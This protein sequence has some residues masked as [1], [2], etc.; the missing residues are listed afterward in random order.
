MSTR[1]I[2]RF[3]PIL[4][5]LLLVL[6][7]SIGHAQVTSATLSGTVTDGTG[8]VI[9]GAAVATT[10]ENTGATRSAE[11]DARGV[12]H[13]PLLSVGTYELR[14]ELQ[15]FQAAV[16]PGIRLT[17]GLE[18]TVN[19]S[20]RV[21][22]VTESVE[23]TGEAPVVAT[24]TSTLSALVDDEQIRNLPLNGRDF[25]Q[26]VLL[27]TGANQALS[28]GGTTRQNTGT[29]SGKRISVSGARVS[30]NLYLVDGTE[31]MDVHRQTPGAVTGGGLGIEAVRE[32][33]LLTNSYSAAHPSQGGAVVNSVTMSGTNSI[34]GSLFEFHRN[35]Q[36]DANDYFLNAAGK[37][38]PG[39]KRNQ[40]GGA[41]GGPVI[42]DRTFFFS[43][44]ELLRQ[45][46]GEA[47]IGRVLDA[48]A[49]MGILPDSAGGNVGVAPD[50][51]PF[52]ALTPQA[53][54]RNFGDG[55]AQ[56]VSSFS[57]PIDQFYWMARVD[58]RFSDSDNFF[59]RYTFD[60]S[61]Q[62]FPSNNIA[63]AEGLGR[64]R[65]QYATAEWNHI[66]SPTWI[67]TA[68]VGFTRMNYNVDDEPLFAEG[69]PSFN[70]P[71]G[72]P[73]GQSAGI[74]FLGG[75]L[76][77][78]GTA[79]NLP[80][81]YIANNF[82]YQDDLTTTQG[83]HQLKFGALLKRYQSNL[84]APQ[85][86]GGAY[87]F[88]NVVAFLQGMPDLW[89]GAL[90]SGDPRG[91]AVRSMRQWMIGT[92]IDD[93]WQVKP[94]F[95]L[96]LGV[97][98]EMSTVPTENHNR[99]ANFRHVRA[100]EPT[101]GPYYKNASQAINIQPRVGF[102][103]DLKGDGKTALRG[104]F[105]TFRMHMLSNTWFITAVRQPPIY[106]IGNVTNPTFLGVF[107]GIDPRAAGRP[108][109][110][111]MDYDRDHAYL[112][113]YNLT[114]QRELIP[115]TSLTVAYAGSR[116]NHLDFL[117]AAN[118][119]EPGT[120]SDGRRCFQPMDGCAGG[121]T[122]RRNSSVIWDARQSSWAQSFYNSLQ[123]NLNRRFQSGIQVAVAYTWSKTIDESFDRWDTISSATN[124]VGGSQ[125]PD[126]HKNDRSLA[127]YHI[128]HNFVT[129]FGYEF[130]TG[131]FDN[132]FARGLINGWR[133]N[134]IVKLSPGNPF[135]VRMGTNRSN[136][137]AIIHSTRPDLVQGADNNPTGGSID[138]YFDPSSFVPQTTGF[139]GTTG[140]NTLIGPGLRNLDL[141]IV[142]NFPFGEERNFE[143][144]AEFFNLTNTAHFRPPFAQIDRGGAGVISQTLPGL[145]T[146]QIQFGVKFAF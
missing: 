13:L 92:F 135:T 70:P 49:R 63:I 123:V 50:I 119:K 91:A 145:P 93:S 71:T 34:H 108:G 47:V 81:I 124:G 131:D 28:T 52:I 8:A 32:F 96:N 24:T 54:G 4:L 104:G 103:W 94:G 77:S 27:Q 67:N 18:A 126:D 2:L 10:N 140:R 55:T 120:F 19:I 117:R 14:V 133:L 101:I 95:T 5:T 65:W 16:R 25:T 44:V 97:R 60:H 134:G 143:F 127:S 88:P 58:H 53:N 33:S 132:L 111:T 82:H 1:R 64:N 109:V 74:G 113:Q 12:Y 3:T 9:P 76:T 17:V 106:T 122:V 87:R 129:S 142:K 136:N 26:L 112:M 41:V 86:L 138:Q 38:R 62:K 90:G 146:R 31:V 105:G 118:T 89:Q 48:N 83:S 6:P 102:A 114:L 23:V 66:F 57:E 144:R 75:A 98:W 7:F 107:R 43:T 141:S 137:G 116:G 22:A 69:L 68:R 59:V 99:L 15:G 115:G 85:N 110:Q 21:G 40:F 84:A 61:T 35:S 100:L 78:I 11:T 56:F 51:A 30:A 73:F 42:Q 45:R 130:P 29:G 72:L 20:L 39:F 80:K 46:R 36:L 128:G 125:D 37:E 139:Y 79:T 121:T